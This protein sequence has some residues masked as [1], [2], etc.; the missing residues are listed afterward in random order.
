MKKIVIT[1]CIYLFVSLAVLF[2]LPIAC[3]NI[4]LTVFNSIFGEFEGLAA[5]NIFM[6]ICFPVLSALIVLIVK[7]KSGEEKRNYLKSME[8]SEYDFRRD[9]KA[10]IKSRDFCVECAI[11]ALIFIVISLIGDPST[12][13]YIIAS[14]LFFGVNLLLTCRF[15]KKWFEQRL[16]R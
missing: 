10:I 6:H 3:S 8:H 13:T 16:H 4:V 15:H 11:F 2:L 5:T 12:V 9:V 14:A 1:F 7:F